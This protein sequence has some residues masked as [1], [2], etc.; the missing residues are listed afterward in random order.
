MIAGAA[1]VLGAGRWLDALSLGED[2]ARSLGV[3]T[4]SLGLSSRSASGSWWGPPPRSPAS[5]ASSA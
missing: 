5:S 2:T 1:I 3:D 4:R